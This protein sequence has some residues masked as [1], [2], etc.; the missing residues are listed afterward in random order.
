MDLRVHPFG[1]VCIVNR[2]WKRSI[3]RMELG[4]DENTNSEK[5]SR[6]GWAAADRE[7]HLEKKIVF[8]ISSEDH[9]LSSVASVGC[10]SCTPNSFPLSSKSGRLSIHPLSQGLGQP[11]ASTVCT[12][13]WT[14]MIGA[15]LKIT[16][17]TEHLVFVFLLKNHILDTKTTISLIIKCSELT[18]RASPSFSSDMVVADALASCE[19]ESNESRFFFNQT[20]NLSP[21]RIL[22]VSSI[23]TV[24]SAIER[25]WIDSKGRCR[26]P[27]YYLQDESSGR[28]IDTN[29]WAAGVV[30]KWSK[31]MV[32]LAVRSNPKGLYGRKTSWRDG[33]GKTPERVKIERTMIFSFFLFLK[34]K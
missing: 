10:W 3:P 23:C 33:A 18:S 21:G 31:P 12:L 30:V 34:I 27:R 14:V 26:S 16:E 22:P 17:K 20:S 25:R 24:N 9:S 11:R 13:C 2:F 6:L 28:V 19:S 5:W 29:G 4:K 7:G 1:T 32:S 15:C 8:V